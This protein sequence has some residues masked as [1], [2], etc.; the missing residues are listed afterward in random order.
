MAD[1]RITTIMLGRE[2]IFPAGTPLKPCK[3]LIFTAFA[4]LAS[5]FSL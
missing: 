3:P 4:A 2:T 1:Q 5:I